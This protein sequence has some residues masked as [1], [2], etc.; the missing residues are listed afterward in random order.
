MSDDIYA[1]IARAA[2]VDRDTMKRVMTAAAYMPPRPI[3]KSP[4]LA[5]PYGIVEGSGPNACEQ[6]EG[7]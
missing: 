2:K 1:D 3:A 6:E 4:N 5:M 7:A